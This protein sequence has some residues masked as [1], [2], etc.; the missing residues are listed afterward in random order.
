LRWVG[1]S[2]D[3]GA[4]TK[5]SVAGCAEAGGG[6]GDFCEGDGGHGRWPAA[7]WVGDSGRALVSCG[8]T[9]RII[10]A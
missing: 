10:P 9:A 5:R 6:I 7:V 1:S 8:G 2:G 3:F 4:L